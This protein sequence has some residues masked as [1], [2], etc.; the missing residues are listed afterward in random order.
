MIPVITDERHALH[1][2]DN[3]VIRG[4]RAPNKEVPKRAEI[5]RSALADAGYVFTAPETFG[6]GPL[7]AVHTKRY[8]DFLM[9]GH[10]EW[11]A[12]GDAAPEII[13]N[14][15]PMGRDAGYPTSIVGRAGM[16][17]G[18]MACPVNGGTWQAACAAADIALTAAARVAAG[19]PAAYG[20]CRP[21]G[22]HAYA[23]HAAGFCFLNNAAIVAEHLRGNG[24]SRV[25]IL[26][27]DVHHGNGTQDIFYDR[28]DV[29]FISLHADPSGFYPFFFG[30]EDQRGEG[31]G[32]GANINYP[33]ALGTDDDGF[34]DALQR[35]CDDLDAFDPGIVVV[36]LGLDIS[37]SDPYAAFRITGDG[38]E[39]IGAQLASLGRPTVVLQEGGY[40]SDVLGDCLV[41]CLAPFG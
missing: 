10:D 27:V 26:D 37:Q 20:L 11:S 2:P 19:T 8:L 3:F 16:H 4:V 36:S 30:Y 25:T 40:I 22:H 23:D 9:N 34:F 32:L 5:L 29:Q 24:T 18:D 41:R 38:F 15:F 12:L 39:R 21:P 13:P 17:Q 35:A 14:A 1:A 31:D 7:E 33:L 6:T 28:G